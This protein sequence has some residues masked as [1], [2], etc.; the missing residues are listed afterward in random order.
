MELEK[1]YFLTYNKVSESNVS[2]N[3]NYVE[4]EKDTLS[5]MQ[6]LIDGYIDHV[7]WLFPELTKNGIDVWIDDEGLLK[8]RSPHVIVYDKNKNDY[9]VSA[10]VGT[11]LFARYDDEGETLGLSLNDI[12][13][14]K[15]YISNTCDYFN[16]VIM[17]DIESIK[18]ES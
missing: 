15:T 1:R 2:D 18:S 3:W 12:E 14:I 13:Y 4:I 9:V 17:K 10:I 7:T 8:N 5:Q 11:I 6:H 16:G